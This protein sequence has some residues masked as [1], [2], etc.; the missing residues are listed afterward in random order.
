MYFTSAKQIVD[1][2]Q[3]ITYSQ[4]TDSEK[5]QEISNISRNGA[6]IDA[7]NKG[8][9]Q[10]LEQSD[11]Q[12]REEMS[13]LADNTRELERNNALVSDQNNKLGEISG[14]LYDTNVI[15]NTGFGDLSLKAQSLVKLAEINSDKMDKLIEVMKI[16]DYEKERL[17][18]FAKATDYLRQSIKFPDR[19]DDAIE[20]LEEIYKTDTRD[21]LV[22]NKLANCYLHSTKH[23]NLVRSKELFERAISYTDSKFND[24]NLLKYDNYINY[25]YIKMLLDPSYVISIDELTEIVNNTINA[26]DMDKSLYQLAAVSLF[27]CG[28]TYSD[29]HDEVIKLMLTDKGL[30]RHTATNEMV[31]SLANGLDEVTKKHDLGEEPTEPMIMAL[32]SAYYSNRSFK[33]KTILTHIDSCRGEV[34]N[35]PNVISAAKILYSRLKTPIDEIDSAEDRRI[36]EKI[37]RKKDR[38]EQKLRE[39][40]EKILAAE[41]KL[42]EEQERRE[43]E[44]KLAEQRET[45]EMLADMKRRE[46][47]GKIIMWILVG[48]IFITIRSCIKG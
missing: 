33:H 27:R 25:A 14:I 35:A 2:N 16:P 36:E 24:K 4:M 28:H 21:P 40:E 15:L 5:R 31:L 11:R 3:L 46:R 39:E 20:I 38:A 13:R 19:M 8:Y 7:I 43:R 47:I 18:K 22:L 41:R 30:I 9:K 10:N 48:F 37:Q 29:Y 23:A 6:V 12:H 34:L 1:S 17:F 45:D 42:I 32:L 44:E 26:K